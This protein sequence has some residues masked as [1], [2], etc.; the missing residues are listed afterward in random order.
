[1][2]LLKTEQSARTLIDL[3]CG[4]SDKISSWI[5]LKLPTAK[6]TL[7]NICRTGARTRM[8]GLL[9]VCSVFVASRVKS[10]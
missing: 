6:F 2:Y 5:V 4:G 3:T 8:S 9:A 10:S 1:M 7:N